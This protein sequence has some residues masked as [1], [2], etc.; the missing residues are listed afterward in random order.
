M[1]E[2]AIASREC[3]GNFLSTGER[4]PDGGRVNE[5]QG[6]GHIDIVPVLLPAAYIRNLSC[7]GIA[8]FAFGVQACEM[9]FL[10]V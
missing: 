4:K 6:P 3:L 2:S 7:Y 5:G 8:P 1:D 9:M 10:S